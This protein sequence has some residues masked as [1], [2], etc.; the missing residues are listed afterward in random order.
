M[1]A[2]FVWLRITLITTLWT[3][4]TI[5]NVRGLNYIIG[6]GY[7]VTTI[8]PIAY[9]AFRYHTDAYMIASRMYAYCMHVHVCQTLWRKENIYFRS[10]FACFSF[11]NDETARDRNVLVCI[12]CMKP[13]FTAEQNYMYAK[14][15]SFLKHFALFEHIRVQN[16]STFWTKWSVKKKKNFNHMFTRVRTYCKYGHFF[17]ICLEAAERTR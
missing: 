12:L 13:F 5:Q 6:L 4:Q 15:M 7:L 14:Q 1:C 8:L 11:R 10:S 2:V 9:G 17:R 16:P 3:P